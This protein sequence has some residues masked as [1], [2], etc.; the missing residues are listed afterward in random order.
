[1][2]L[3]HNIFYADTDVFK[4]IDALKKSLSREIHKDTVLD[5]PLSYAIRRG[6]SPESMAGRFVDKVSRLK[7]DIANKCLFVTNYE[8]YLAV[9]NRR[10]ALEITQKQRADAR[11]VAEFVDF[12]PNDFAVSNQ[13]LGF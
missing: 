7:Q 5:F 3:L 12:A 13:R 10:S 8:A 2:P 6:F 11:D 1:M 9:K 4:D